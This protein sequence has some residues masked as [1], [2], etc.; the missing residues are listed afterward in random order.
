MFIDQAKVYVKAGD[1][2]PGCVSF[3][4]EKFMP[5]GG[6]DGGDGGRGASIF[7]E[8]VKDVDTLLDFSGRHQIKGK[9]G[10]PG[11]G[12]N[13]SGSAG[14]DVVVPVPLGTLIYDADLGILL[15]D[16]TEI[17]MK[18]CICKG[19]IGGRGNKKFATST[20]QTPKH[21]QPG[22]PGQER[23]LRLELKLI[24]DIGL[25]GLPNAGKS[26]L[27]SRCSAAKPK[28]ANYPFTTL[29]PVLGIVEITGFR[30]F[31]MADIPGLIEGASEGAG[32]GH[33]FL[34]HIERT[35]YIAHLI[36]LCPMDQS[37]PVENYFKIRKELEKY[38]S[39]LADKPEIVVANKTDLDPDGEIFKDVKERIG[40][41]IIAVSAV[42]GENTKQL[43]E[44]LWEQI[45]EQKNPPEERGT[46]KYFL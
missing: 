3:Q 42:T 19:G 26:T 39:L 35:R 17:G 2:G 16:M 12:R 37:D 29:E 13:R 1:G 41:D 30:T 28:I 45:N 22:R 8:A 32:L 36:E 38:S 18:V 44:L 43:L 9:N 20:N 24:A 46:E 6:P 34:K 23:N 33:D 25:V 15:K 10:L 4:R 14:E 7:F 31:V 40:K 5:K 21:A 11:E 27:I